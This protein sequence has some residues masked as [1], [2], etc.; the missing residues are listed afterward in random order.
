MRRSA[1]PP[2]PRKRIAFV[3]LWRIGDAVAATAGLAAL[4]LVRPEAEIAI[5]AHPDSGDPLFR[6]LPDARHIR[7]A[8]FWTRGKLWR[9]K[10]LP[11][12]IDYRGLG[13]AWGELRRFAPDVCLLFRGD[14]REQLLCS[15]LGRVEIVD[16]RKA[17]W[18]PWVHTVPVTR[19]VPRFQ[20]YVE[21]IRAWSGSS[22]V[23]TP[24]LAGVAAA[25]ERDRSHVLVHPGASWRFK[26]WSESKVAAVLRALA[27]RGVAVKLVGGEV[28]REVIGRICAQLEGPVDVVFPSLAEFYDLVAAARLV[29]CNNSAALHIAEAL[30]TPCIALTGPNDPVRWGTY[31]PHSR[32]IERSVGLPCHP[33]AEKRCVRPDHPCIEEI[34]VDDVLA[35]VRPLAHV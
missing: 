3:E 25:G 30:G 19:G 35:A 33:C 6:L 20:E 10:Y 4:A 15:S 5:V 2:S 13:T 22:V 7:L 18:L 26:Q 9:D 28:D 27:S 14:V 17:P 21:L 24:S 34:Q 8:A 1:K 29:I 23:A 12:T 32:T 11:W 31:R 16:F